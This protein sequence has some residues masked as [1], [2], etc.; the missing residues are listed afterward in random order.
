MNNHGLDEH[1]HIIVRESVDAASETQET[2]VKV[3]VVI[4]IYKVEPYLRQCLDSVVGQTYQNLEIICVDDGSPDRCGEICE[5]YAEK[6]DRI[7]VIHRENGGLSAARN[8]GI[9]AA[10]GE[11]ICFIDSD[12][13][14]RETFVEYL[15]GLIKKYD[16]EIAVCPLF[17]LVSEQ[18]STMQGG[19]EQSMTSAEALSYI[20][21]NPQY[22]GVFAWNKMYHRGLFTSIRYP[23]GK[24][25]EDSG[26][27]YRL[28]L[29]SNRIAIGK[30]PQYYYRIARA[31]QITSSGGE[32][33]LDKIEFLYQMKEC[34]I[35]Q[36]PEVLEAYERYMLL[37]LVDI[38]LSMID[39]KPS[40]EIK[41]IL[42]TNLLSENKY[43]RERGLRLSFYC[44][45][46][47][48][49]A[50]YFPLFYNILRKAKHKWSVLK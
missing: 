19:A 42:R 22:V 28:F 2:D 35:S 12:D 21:L 43:I 6:D 26:T 14:V 47:T 50:L 41:K 25:Y 10:T 1:E 29:A 5:E 17:K 34:F 23:E 16:A 24:Y 27:T 33:K 30:E 32:K 44:R 8:T 37:S 20:F 45:L 36:C 4:P 3:S 39:E 13:F 46:K 9:D 7:R 40:R 48:Y 49:S 15:Y 31:G 18:T 38:Y 11:Y